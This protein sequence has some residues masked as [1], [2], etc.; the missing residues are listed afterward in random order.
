MTTHTGPDRR[1]ASRKF[2]LAVAAFLAGCGF[3]L[4]AKI[5]PEQWQTFT[6]WVLGLYIAGNIGDT[7]A[8]RLR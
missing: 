3:L 2:L 5:A 7:A 8:E 6:Q 4:S 1:Y